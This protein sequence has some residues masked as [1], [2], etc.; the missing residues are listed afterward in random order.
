MEKLVR[1]IEKAKL[2][3]SLPVPLRF[4]VPGVLAG[5][6]V[7][8]FA[9]TGCGQKGASAGTVVAHVGEREVKL[10][11]ITDHLDA[12][13]LT[14]SS[15]S[16]ELNARRRQLE[17][18][19]EEQLLIIG[20]YARTLDADIGVIE[21]VDTEKD[22]YL[23]DELYRKEITDKIA[24]PESEIRAMYEHWFDRTTFRHIVLFDADT[25]AIVAQRARKGDDF[26]DLAAEFSQDVNSRMGGGELGREFGWNELPP[27]HATA[28]FALKPNEIGGP[29]N[30]GGRWHVIRMTETKKLPERDYETVQPSIESILRRN[31]GNPMR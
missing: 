14:Y 7:T 18:L 27:E 1:V 26:G 31:R 8:L 4:G 15:A 28:I 30:I 20:G 9:S 19:V 21:E 23:L 16:D 22:R 24:V 12:L 13:Q 3:I 5:I 10:R 17:K 29:F 11:Q 2:G 6:L 25:A